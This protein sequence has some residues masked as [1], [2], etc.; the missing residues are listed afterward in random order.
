MSRTDGP[1][2]RQQYCN[3]PRLP[4]CSSGCRS[5]S[6]S[7][8]GLRPGLFGIT[9]LW[10]GGLFGSPRK[11]ASESAWKRR[12]ELR[13]R[14]DCVKRPF[15]Y[16]KKIPRVFRPLRR[17]SWP[18]RLPV[19][20]RPTTTQTQRDTNT[21]LSHGSHDTTSILDHGTSATS[22]SSAFLNFVTTTRFQ[23]NVTFLRLSV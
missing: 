12:P 14:S 13:P 3:S 20:R 16:P 21:S 17:S 1:P 18:K 19:G 23:F 5:R 2:P 15:A 11:P 8:A 9:G 10:I 22:R 6:R 7:R 4:S